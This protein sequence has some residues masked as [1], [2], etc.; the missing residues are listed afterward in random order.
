M[1]PSWSP[2]IPSWIHDRYT[3]DPWA[4][5]DY[6]RERLDEGMLREIAEADYAQDVDQHLEALRP[7]VRGERFSEIPCWYPGEVLELTRWSNPVSDDVR[8]HLM[9]GFSCAALWL[10]AKGEYGRET[11]F[12]LLESALAVDDRR[13]HVALLRAMMARFNQEMAYEGPEFGALAIVILF[14]RG[15]FLLQQTEE[16]ALVDW[17]GEIADRN[18]DCWR[19]ASPWI[20]EGE[21]LF[22]DSFGEVNDGKWRKALRQL[23]DD[24]SERPLGWL[25]RERLE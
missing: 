14:H 21:W 12:P 8:G 1:P 18:Y 24:F 19:N 20:G 7:M 17:F 9:R 6:Y 3:A 16:K 22:T 5:L 4:A 11:L 23:R 2:K 25:L 13:A 10:D 15:R